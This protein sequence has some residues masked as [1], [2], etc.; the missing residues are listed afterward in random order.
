MLYRE[1]ELSL[2]DMEKTGN[3][4]SQQKVDGD[5]FKAECKEIK[6]TYDSTRNVRLVNRHENEYSNN[7]P[8]IVAGLG[9]KKGI[10]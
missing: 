10:N 7:F 8:E 5:N 2:S 9:V 4:V 6:N 1:S 3:F